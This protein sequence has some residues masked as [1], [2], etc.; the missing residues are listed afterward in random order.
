MKSSIIKTILIAL[1]LGVFSTVVLVSAD[2]TL[3]T[4]LPPPLDTKPEPETKSPSAPTVQCEIC[5][6]YCKVIQCD[7]WDDN[8][9]CTKSHWETVECGTYSC[10]CHL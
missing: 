10:N 4:K 9:N 6:K 8:L 7:H 5:T 1:T 3:D 2:I